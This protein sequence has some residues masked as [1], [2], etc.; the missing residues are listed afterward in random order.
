MFDS[1]LRN[2]V[3]TLEDLNLHANPQLVCNQ[4]NLFYTYHDNKAHEMHETP[5]VTATVGPA[6]LPV[7]VEDPYDKCSP[8][9]TQE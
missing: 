5:F 7:E 1:E 3:L 2:G 4:N 9:K 8:T 6:A